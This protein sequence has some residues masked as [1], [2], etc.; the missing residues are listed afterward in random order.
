MESVSDLC[1]IDIHLRALDQV[2]NRIDRRRQKSANMIHDNNMEY[3][4]H[5]KIALREKITQEEK[6]AR[7]RSVDKA[8]FD[9]SKFFEHELKI[10]TTQIYP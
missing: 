7:L 6:E 5:T 1:E 10:S 4:N 8:A 2:G 3:A 9:E